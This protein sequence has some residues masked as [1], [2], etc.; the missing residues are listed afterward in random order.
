MIIIVSVVAMGVQVLASTLCG[1]HVQAR[2][3]TQL[4]LFFRTESL[5]GLELT[6]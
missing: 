2:G 3:Q 6:K 4:S 1:V 5:I